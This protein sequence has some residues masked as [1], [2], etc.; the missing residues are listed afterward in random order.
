MTDA[1]GVSHQVTQSASAKGGVVVQ[2]GRDGTVFFGDGL[3]NGAAGKHAELDGWESAQ[4]RL[5]AYLDAAVEVFERDLGRAG[6]GWTPVPMQVQQVATRVTTAAGGGRARLPA[7]EVLGDGDCVLVGEPG[8]GKT[9]ALMAG[10]LRIIARW[11]DEV[12]HTW[13]PVF[14]RAVDLVSPRPLPEV[15]ASAVNARFGALGIIRSWSSGFFRDAPAP[16]GRWLVLVDGLD[17]VV[18]VSL[19]RAVLEMLEGF[20]RRASATYG[21]VLT[22]RPLPDPTARPLPDDGI[23]DTWGLAKYRMLPLGRKSLADLAGRC[24]AAAG[25]AEPDRLVEQFLRAVDRVGVAKLSRVPL[26]ATMLCELYLNR[27][28]DALPASRYR[29]FDSYTALLGERMFTDDAS[30]VAAQ[31]RAAVVTAFGSPA[32]DEADQLLDHLPDVV[33]AIA[34]IQRRSPERTTLD[35]LDKTTQEHRPPRIPENLW[36][37]VVVATARRTGLLTQRGADLVFPHRFIG[38]FLAARRVAGNRRE[39]AHVFRRMFGSV[40][41]RNPLSRSPFGSSGEDDASDASSF[42]RFLIETWAGRKRLRWALHLLVRRRDASGLE[43]CRLVIALAEE[44]M[45][46]P[47][48]VLAATTAALTRTAT[49]HREPEVRLAAALELAK[50]K[51]ERSHRLLEALTGDLTSS[52]EVRLSAAVGMA[53]LGHDKAP[54]V[55]STLARDHLGSEDSRLAA[56]FELLQHAPSLGADALH[57]LAFSPTIS[58]PLRL[59]ASTELLAVDRDRGGDAMTALTNPRTVAPH[60]RLLAALQLARFDDRRAGAALADLA[61]ERAAAFAVRF[62]A[63]VELGRLGDTRRAY[64]LHQLAIDREVAVPH[65]L[66]A[67]VQL[68]ADDPATAR[69]VVHGLASDPARHPDF[70]L[71]ATQQ[72]IALEDPRGREVL[73]DLAVGLPLDD[74]IR[75]DVLS[76]LIRLRDPAALAELARTTDHRANPD[77]TTVQRAQL[78]LDRLVDVEGIDGWGGVARLAHLELPIRLKAIDQLSK[79]NTTRART[80]LADLADNTALDLTIRK[81]AANALKPK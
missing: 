27:Q 1:S 37:G 10:A 64:W 76:D 67:A 62:S 8:S 60:D 77:P 23:P 25:A 18:S 75:F 41:G 5:S 36:R 15:L 61:G 66:A 26:M 30:S 19:R 7:H 53:G 2:I 70:R 24:F 79:L 80:L 48:G 16:A 58:V 55:L 51:D 31:L 4:A 50:I 13:V 34:L 38:D 3:G 20:S 71:V 78:T 49:R 63:A 73:I 22:T 14:V 11:R 81:A 56:A 39:S 46:L 59:Q 9:T 29:L 68:A 6:S 42:C 40:G 57:H 44:G 52:F 72:L 65:R 17:E 33:A 54:A 12:D 35:L 28:S 69:D 45:H 21:F 74:D 47:G 43:G 32:A